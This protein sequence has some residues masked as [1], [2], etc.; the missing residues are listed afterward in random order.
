MFRIA[1]AFVTRRERERERN[2]KNAEIEEEE[3]WRRASPCCSRSRG[4]LEFRNIPLKRLPRPP[5]P[6]PPVGFA[7]KFRGTEAKH[8]PGGGHYARQRM[9]RILGLLRPCSDLFSPPSLREE[10]R[11][12]F[13]QARFVLGWNFAVEINH[14]GQAGL[15]AIPGLESYF[16]NIE[17]DRHSCSLVVDS[18]RGKRRPPSSE[19]KKTLAFFPW[20]KKRKKRETRRGRNFPQPARTRVESLRGGRRRKERKGA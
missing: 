6:S 1:T 13:K 5:P 20:R 7:V 8:S 3:T 18:I 12:I 14:L 17:A 4:E 9:T 15:C 10:G 2:W 11:P 16:F 19:V